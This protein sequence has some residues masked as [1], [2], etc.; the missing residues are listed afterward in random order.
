M[1]GLMGM[2][3]QVDTLELV[4]REQQEMVDR[5]FLVESVLTHRGVS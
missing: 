3:G 2:G 4:L 5:I 1:L